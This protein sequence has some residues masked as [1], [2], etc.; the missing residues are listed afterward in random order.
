[1]DATYQI[2][3]NFSRVILLFLFTATPAVF[4]AKRKV[5]ILPFQNREK[6]PLYDYLEGSITD[7]VT[8][9]LQERFVFEQV[10]EDKWRANAAQNLVH[11]GEFYTQTAGMQLGA[12]LKQDVVI[13]GSFIVSQK[14]LTQARQKYDADGKSGTPVE[15]L[16]RPENKDAPVIVTT[17]RL[18]DISKRKLVTEFEVEG[19]ADAS[20]FESVDA[21][22]LR[23]SKEAA[24]VLPNE[25]EWKARADSDW[26]DFDDQLAFTLS[27]GL[28]STP[29]AFAG[30][31]T[32]GSQIIPADF[33]PI[34]GTFSYR[35]RKLFWRDLYLGGA[36]AYG[37][38]SREFNVDKSTTAISASSDALGLGVLVGYEWKIRDRFYAAPGIRFGYQLAHIKLDY[39][40]LAAKPL[41]IDGKEVTSRDFNSSSPVL[42][43]TGLAGWRMTSSVSLELR[44]EYEMQ[45]Y[46]NRYSAQL[47]LGAGVS[48]GLEL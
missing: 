23:V 31:L 27:G 18:F 19:F 38:G 21:L 33:H 10:A 5:L 46:A 29:S 35:R 8:K 9:K 26:P 7:A 20:I 13:S 17:V 24:A 48:V 1:M 25:E 2:R 11:P 42:A 37:R 34:A 14:P 47:F 41:D 36:L 4:A 32:S 3:R 15:K 40:S 30:T 6:N 12:W 45:L 22:A 43:L 44:S 39:S 16:I 28:I